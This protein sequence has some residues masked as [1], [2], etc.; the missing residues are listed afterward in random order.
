MFLGSDKVKVARAQTLKSEFKALAMS[1]EEQLD[2]FYLKLNGLVTNIRSLG[3]KVDEANDVSGR[4]EEWRK[5][6]SSDGQ[7]LLTRDE[8]QKWANREGPRGGE[9]RRLRKERETPKEANMSNVQEDEPA[10]LIAEVGQTDN[11]VML[12][13][14][15]ALVAK[16]QTNI[17][18]QRESQVWYLDNGASNN[19]I[20]QRGKFKELDERVSGKTNHPIDK[21]DDFSKKMWVYLLKEKSNAFEMFKRFKALVENETEKRIK[22]LRIDRGGEFFSNEFRRTEEQDCCCHGEELPEGGNLHVYLWGEAV[23]YSIYVL[24]GVPTRS[25]NGQTPYEAWNGDKLDLTHLKV[26]GCTAFVKIP[27]KNVKKLDNR[28]EKMVYLGKEP[29]TK[30]SRLFNPEMGRVHVSR[31]IVTE[32]EDFWPWEKE[33]NGEVEFSGNYVEIN[34]FT[35]MMVDAE[36]E[37]NMSVPTSDGATEMTGASSATSTEPRRFRMLDDICD[38]T[39]VVDQIDELMLLKAEK[40]MSFREAVESRSNGKMQWRLK[41]VYKL[42][43]DLEGNVVKYKARLIAKGYV[44]RK[45]VDYDEVFAPVARL[46]TVRLLLALSAKEEWKVHHLD[47]KLVFL[48]GELLE[49]KQKVVALS[50]CEA[51]YMAATTSACQSIWLRGL[52]KEITRQLVGPMVLYIDNRSAIELMKNPVLDGRGKHIDV[53]FHF[54]RE[55][56]E[57]GELVVKH[58]ST[59]EQRA[60]ILTKAFGPVKFE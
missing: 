12:L 42:K 32:E 52:L 53:R 31:D 20:G 16:L 43:R 13:K 4:E 49:E 22:T 45:E 54:I 10:L 17:E 35:E 30:G 11:E 39:E 34:E 25:L 8:W 41:W 48:N 33:T 18:G 3:E 27:L 5:K 7:L 46:D 37:P 24:N 2:D 19:M 47:I 9:Y 44:Q 21:V 55:C 58:V 29:G 28:S 6:E 57:R 56:I 60:G 38:S 50:S 51:E 26:F 23:R 40:A 36:Q 15:D 1:E 14:E 59:Q